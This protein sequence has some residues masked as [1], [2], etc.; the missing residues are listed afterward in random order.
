MAVTERD[1][2]QVEEIDQ[3]DEQ[4]VAPVSMILILSGVSMRMWSAGSIWK[5]CLR[6]V[7][8]W[9]RERIII[10]I[11]TRHMR[12]YNFAGTIFIDYENKRDFSDCNTLVYGHN[13]KN[14]SMFGMLKSTERMRRFIIPANISGSSHRKRL[15]VWDHC[16][17]YD[18][19]K[20]R[21]VYLI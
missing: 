12:N 11:C 5:H 15:P 20:Q 10:F 2:D 16:S 3:P 19:C 7:I 17:V 8:R 18:F 13:M 1:P 4:P 9:Y 6:S 14:G 21:Y